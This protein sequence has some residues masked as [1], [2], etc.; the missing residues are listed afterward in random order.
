M[1]T[2]PAPRLAQACGD[3][4]QWSFKRNCSLTPRQLAAT[5]ALLSGVSLA[6]AAFFWSL[7]V[8]L[9]LAFTALELAAVAIAFLVYGRHAANRERIALDRHH[10]VVE[11]ERAGQVSREVFNRQWARVADRPSRTALIEICE[12]P[13]CVRCGHHVRPD[14][15]EQVARE[16]RMA[17]RGFPAP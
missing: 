16:I 12:G 14:L 1:S 4:L 8:R 17:L 6:V 5:Y 2:L 15:R 7:G 10:L 3:S 13:R 9:I 11:Q